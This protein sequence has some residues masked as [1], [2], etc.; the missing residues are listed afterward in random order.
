MA[1]KMIWGR[2]QT[3]I[4]WG[5]DIDSGSEWKLTSNA[6][7][8]DMIKSRWHENVVNPAVEVAE[9]DGSQPVETVG[10]AARGGCSVA[11]GTSGVT[12][13]DAAG[14][15]EGGGVGVTGDT[16][17]SPDNA[18]PTYGNV[19]WSTLTSIPEAA[20]DGDML[21]LVDEDKVFDAMGF[22]E[23]DE[24]AAAQAKKKNSPSEITSTIIHEARA[25]PSAPSSD[26]D[27]QAQARTRT[28]EADFG[29][30]SNSLPCSRLR[31]RGSRNDGHQRLIGERPSVEELRRPTRGDLSSSPRK[32]RRGQSS[33]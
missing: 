11:Q 4:I 15:V 25:L 18:E 24:R 12:D 14:S 30:H 8:E 16:C 27:H 29:K 5:V 9:K 17:T 33:R 23:A 32:H 13:A 2:T 19:D 28:N 10:S 6:Q 31:G 21:A 22:K 20:N 1:G 26:G 3:L 7:F